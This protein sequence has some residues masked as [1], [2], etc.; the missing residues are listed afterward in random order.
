MKLSEKY[1]QQGN[2]IIDILKKDTNKKIKQ[3]AIESFCEDILPLLLG[4]LSVWIIMIGLS[5][6]MLDEALA[7]VRWI[8]I[9]LLII[10]TYPY[11]RLINRTVNMWWNKKMDFELAKNLEL[12]DYAD[13]I[14]ESLN[15]KISEVKSY[16]LFCEDDY[17]L[18]NVI[19]PLQNKGLSEETIISICD[20]LR[21][22]TVKGNFK[23]A[24]DYINKEFGVNIK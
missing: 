18:K 21:D 1:I 23:P 2:H 7:Y 9:S 4:G 12:S 8:P 15:I 19:H 20:Y 5:F 14:W 24:V 16:E 13:L 22:E 17:L 6:V 10:I 3:Y 11:L